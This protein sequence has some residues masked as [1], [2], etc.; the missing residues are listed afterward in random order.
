MPPGL[1]ATREREEKRLILISAATELPDP[2]QHA[3]ACAR[4]GGGEG[5]G[6]GKE[7]AGREAGVLCCSSARLSV[8]EKECWRLPALSFAPLCIAQGLSRGKRAGERKC[9]LKES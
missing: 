2:C 6:R 4:A 9:C 7:L 1:A 5:G 8:N 3:G